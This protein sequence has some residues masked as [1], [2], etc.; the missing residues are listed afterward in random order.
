MPTPR[1][2]TNQGKRRGKQRG[3]DHVHSGFNVSDGI[4]ATSIPTQSV[5]S[6]NGR[7]HVFCEIDVFVLRFGS[8]LSSSPDH[9]ASGHEVKVKTTSM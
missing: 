1:C 7:F 6:N 4:L 5:L 2:I 9:V 8:S 3:C